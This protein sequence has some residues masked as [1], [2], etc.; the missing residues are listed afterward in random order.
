METIA[1][2]ASLVS[3]TTSVI[4]AI[5]GVQE[6]QQ[7]KLENE[8]QKK[9]WSKYFKS[10]TGRDW[11]SIEKLPPLEFS[12]E[13]NNLYEYNE[14]IVNEE[15]RDWYNTQLENQVKAYFIQKANSK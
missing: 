12:G 4:S 10:L 1:I 2:V 14:K 13:L 8:E 5:L 11:K 6:F 9:D 15:Q 7:R 3:L